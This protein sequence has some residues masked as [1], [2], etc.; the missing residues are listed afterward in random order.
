MCCKILPIALGWALNL[1]VILRLDQA[2]WHTSEQLRVPEGIHL[3]FLPAYSPELQPAERLWTLVEPLANVAFESLDEV[4]ELVYQRCRRLL[5]Q[6][7]LIRGL[8]LYHWLPDA[9]AA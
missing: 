1:R 6:Q 2:R 3:I 7:E 4:E 8:T 9:E 5:Q